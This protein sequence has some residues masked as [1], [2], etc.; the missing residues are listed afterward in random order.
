L[1][2]QPLPSE[3]SR[4]LLTLHPGLFFRSTKLFAPY[5]TSNR[6]S[7]SGYFSFRHVGETVM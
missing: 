3:G 6:F 1:Q 4:L 7:Y 5:P 2:S